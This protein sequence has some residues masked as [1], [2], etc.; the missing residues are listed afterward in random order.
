MKFYYCVVVIGGGVVGVFVLYYLVKFGWKDVCLIECLILIV[1]FSWYVVGG[2][3]VLNVDFNI[4]VFQVYIIDFFSEIQEELGQDIGFY[5]I[6]GFIMVGMFDCW[7][8]L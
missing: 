2:I 5:M 3:Y 7:E 4:V 6:G 8:W 1:G